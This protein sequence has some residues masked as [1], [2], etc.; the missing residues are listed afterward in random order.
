MLCPDC[1]KTRFQEFLDSNK[2]ANTVAQMTTTDE[3]SA[4]ACASI[5]SSSIESDDAVYQRSELLSYVRFYRDR[6]SADKMRKV[7]NGFYSAREINIAKKLLISSFAASF[8][9]C[10]LKSERR[11]S[12]AR[13]VHEAEVEDIIGIF[14]YLDQKSSDALNSVIFVA[15]DF[16]RI[17][18]YG[19]EELNI[20]TIADKQCEIEARMTALSSQFD[21]FGQSHADHWT[22]QL[23]C[24]VLSTRLNL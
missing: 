14:E 20:C 7:I 6:A 17:P 18:K 5:T 4:R 2:K 21:A 3:K 16:D 15:T 11:K 12:A 19:P 1:D 23:Q 9:D 13:E 22:S 24:N 10:P 8:A